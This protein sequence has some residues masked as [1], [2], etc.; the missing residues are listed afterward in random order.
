MDVQRVSFDELLGVK[1][2]LYA[3]I[4]SDPEF[5]SDHAVTIIGVEMTGSESLLVRLDPPLTPLIGPKWSKELIHYSGP[6]SEVTLLPRYPH[7]QG[8]VPPG[9]GF[10]IAV[11]IYFMPDPPLERGPI[12]WNSPD[13]WGNL[14]Y[15]KDQK[16]EV[17][18]TH[19]VTAGHRLPAEYYLPQPGRS[20]S[21]CIGLVTL[22]L[23]AAV[24]AGAISY[25]LPT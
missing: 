12:Y 1:L 6:I 14:I 24:L 5:Q 7:M 15:S 20:R 16:G 17:R 18:T 23:S 25:M 4:D 11:H 22:V 2:H 10:P 3:G 19:W 21:G 8:L 9:P 13:D